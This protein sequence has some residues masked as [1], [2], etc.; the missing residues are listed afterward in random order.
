MTYRLGNRR[1]ER[2]A[3]NSDEDSKR[4]LHVGSGFDQ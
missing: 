4:V 3:R 2:N 1:S